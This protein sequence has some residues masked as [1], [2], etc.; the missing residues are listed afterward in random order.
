MK[1]N[2]FVFE[3]AFTFGLRAILKKNPLRINSGSTLLDGSL[4][5][6]PLTGF[7]MLNLV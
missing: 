2:H 6:I 5:Y 3:P 7:R 1:G 4:I